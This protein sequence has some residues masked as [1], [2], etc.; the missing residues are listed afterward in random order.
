MKNILTYLFLLLVFSGCVRSYT[1][2]RTVIIEQESDYQEDLS[3]VRPKYE[4]RPEEKAEEAVPQ[5]QTNVQKSEPPHINKEV[6]AIIDRIAT[7]NKSKT[8]ERGYRIQVF[9]GNDRTEYEQARSY[10]LQY[11]PSLET[12]VTYSQ[13]TYRLKVGDFLNRADAEN[14]LNSLQSRFVAAKIIYD[15]VNYK[16][17]LTVK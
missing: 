3:L 10:V 16:K 15:N 5:E 13:P 17:A 6:D 12:Y 9:A 8:V 11:F 7:Q 2:S 4:P 1:P 14:Y